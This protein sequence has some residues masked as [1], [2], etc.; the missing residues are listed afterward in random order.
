MTNQ[1]PPREIWYGL[2]EALELLAV[3]EDARDALTDSRHLAVV[4][5]VE[6]QIRSLSRK[7]DFDGPEASD[8][9]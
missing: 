8:A 5:E 1:E 4:V 7:L 3:L 9:G 2:D 6:A